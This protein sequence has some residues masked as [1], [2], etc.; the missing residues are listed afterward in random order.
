[1]R[2]SST[3]CA[4]RQIYVKTWTGRTITVVIDLES[5]VANLKRVVTAKTGIP[6]ESQQ[7]AFGG[8]ALTDKVLMKEYNISEGETIEMTGI[9]LGGMKKKSLIPRP[10]DTER[11][12]KRKESEPCIEVGD[13]IEDENAQT[14]LDIDPPDNAKW[15]E[16]T[17]KRLQDRTDDVSELEIN[18]S[19]VQRQMTEVEKRLGIVL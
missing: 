6:T 14:H 19:G 1:M 18:M 11:D 3:V 2:I 13:S 12:K 9:L 10:M 8:K 7:L 15:I 16:D 17:I 5:E 4:K